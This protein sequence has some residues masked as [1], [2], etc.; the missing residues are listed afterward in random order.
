MPC[1]GLARR[2]S[3]VGSPP[4]QRGFSW[5][6]TAFLCAV[7]GLVRAGPTA[8]QASDQAGTAEQPYNL[9]VN[10]G[11]EQYDPPYAQWQGVDCQVA[12]GWQR[13]WYGA[14]EPAWMDARVFAASPLGCGWV[15]HFEGQTAQFIVSTQPYSAGILQRVA[16]VTPG[17]GYGFNAVVLNIF[18]SSAQPRQDGTMIVQVGLDPTGGVDPLAPAVVWSEPF[19]LDKI[20]DHDSRV[21]ALARGSEM[22]AFVRILSLY[23]AGPWPFMNLSILDKALLAQTPTVAAASPA[24][25]AQ[26]TFVVSWDG[27]QP[28]PGGSELL[29]RDVQWLDEAEGVW[30]DWI[31]HTYEVA[32]SFTGLPGHIYRFRARVW[33]NYPNGTR[34]FSPYRSEGDSRTM[35]AGARIAGQVL[36]PAEQPAPGATAALTGTG[37]TTTG[38][39]FRVYLPVIFALRCYP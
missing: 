6:A 28:A 21:S 23:P 2:S 3:T 17:T 35:V 18:Q 39:P 1:M 31:T 4:R 30:H 38:G 16:G 37:Y 36:S 34:L 14:S 32:S 19:A 7:L 12:T 5:L 8:A 9:L 11:L 20:I 29:W 33:Q 22:T 15:E 27:A 26:P 25:S 13:F 10:P 24:C